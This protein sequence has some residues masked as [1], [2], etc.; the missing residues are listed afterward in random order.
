MLEK[1]QMHYQPVEDRLALV[2]TMKTGDMLNL[3][4]TRR[5]TK[6]LLGSLGVLVK[7][8]ENVISQDSV[9]RKQ[10]VE[11][12]QKEQAAEKS[13]FSQERI[14][15]SKPMEGPKPTLVADVRLD[16]KTLRLPMTDG[17]TLN[18]EMSTQLAYVIINLINSTVANTDWNL[19]KKEQTTPLE[20]SH[21]RYPT[22]TLN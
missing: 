2:I 1:V 10:Y 16:N 20:Y 15:F 17:K 19:V 12:F 9:Q 4:L 21:Q 7:K 11:Q 6:K 22:M 8:D 5:V 3:W 18:L 14:D 13:K